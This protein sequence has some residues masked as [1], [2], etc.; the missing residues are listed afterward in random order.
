MSNGDGA[1]EALKRLMEALDVLDAAL[2]TRLE[3]DRRRGSL[4]D[5]LHAFSTD[6]ARLAD[7]LDLAK[8]RTRELETAN[9]EAA[10]RLE[11]AITL[12][13]T[14]MTNNHNAES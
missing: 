2:E 7:E 9:H 8:A 5:Q 10:N 3:N 4:E 1:D 14:V 12:V 11:K 6:R 13:R